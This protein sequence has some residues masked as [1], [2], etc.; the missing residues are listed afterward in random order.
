MRISD[1]IRMGMDYVILGIAVVLFLGV[2]F[3]LWYFLWFKKKRQGEKLNKGKVLLWAFFVI[4]AVVLIGATML[5]G[6][7]YGNARI[8]PLFYSY[9]DAWNDFSKTEWQNIILNICLFVPLGI[10]LPMLIKKADKF[11]NV[12]LIG[13]GVTCFIE[14]VQLVLNIGIFEP[15]DL[16]GNTVGVMIGYGIYRI[17]HYVLA[18]KKG[19]MSEKLIRVLGFQ[20]PLLVTVLSFGG[21][22]LAYYMKELGNI[23]EAYIIKQK[24]ID[25]HSSLEFSDEKESAMVYRADIFTLDETRELAEQIFKGYGTNIDDESIDAYENSVLYY[26]EDRDFSVWVQYDGGTFSFTNFDKLFEEITEDKEEADVTKD[27]LSGALDAIGIFVPKEAEIEAKSENKYLLG[28]ETVKEN[29]KMYDGKLECTYYPDGSFG[30]IEYNIL[31]LEDYKEFPLLS[32]K[33]A[34]QKLQDGEFVYYRAD[35]TVL[36]IEVLEVNLEYVLDTK[37]FYQPVY[38]FRV[39]AGEWW[40]TIMIPAIK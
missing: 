19:D 3:L 15:D 9:I 39:I 18:K 5:R 6:S 17:L 40:T 12:Y 37:G 11:W 30:R 21:I 36:D 28:V 2:A 20:I 25:V 4:Y 38:Q 8:Y 24:N 16:L 7:Y 26:S 14:V 35:D 34:Y 27:E 23:S 29:G 13:F 31:Q 33:E 1:I 22:F 32:K 10:F